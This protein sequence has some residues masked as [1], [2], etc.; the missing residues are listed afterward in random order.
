IRAMGL[1]KADLARGGR[2]S[3][4]RIV[5]ALR[6]LG[7]PLLQPPGPDGWPEEAEAWITPQGLAAR[8]SFAGK[9]GQLIAKRSEADPRVFAE[10]A[11]RDALRP[12]TAFT[13]GGAPERWEG[14]ALTLA[15]P[16]FNRR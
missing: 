6:D 9:V 3:G 1:K 13:V 2:R 10:A 14:F 11:L 4:L 7:Q 16:E 15:S 8:L 12:E 5:R